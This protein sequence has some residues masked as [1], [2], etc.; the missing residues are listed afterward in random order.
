MQQSYICTQQT[1]WLADGPP[2]TCR[3]LPAPGS[4]MARAVMHLPAQAAGMYR[5]FCSS[6]PK[7]RTYGSTISAVY[8]FGESG[9]DGGET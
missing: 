6:V 5:C 3:S 4:V 1:G 7:C 8:R 2:R 9:R